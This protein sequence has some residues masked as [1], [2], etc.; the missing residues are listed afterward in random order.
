[1]GTRGFIVF[2]V[3]GKD[4]AFYN[5]YDSYPTGLGNEI[6]NFIQSLDE[7]RLERMA[8]NIENLKM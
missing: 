3:K 7:G 8:N 5:H 6:I 4:V 2:R 1:M